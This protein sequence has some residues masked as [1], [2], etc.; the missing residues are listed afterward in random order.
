MNGGRYVAA[1]VRWPAGESVCLDAVTHP[2]PHGIGLAESALIDEK[3]PLGSSTQCLPD[4][5][6][7][8]GAGPWRWAVCAVRVRRFAP[9]AEVP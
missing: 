9:A 3:G 6:R 4:C 8:D 2:R 1:A 5:G 7:G